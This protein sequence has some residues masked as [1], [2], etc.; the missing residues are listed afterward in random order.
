[1]KTMEF[2]VRPVAGAT[3]RGMV[4]EGVASAVINVSAGEEIS[5]N[6]RQFDVAAHV[7]S[8]NDLVM[9]LAD[10]RTVTLKGFFAEG[11]PIA[12]LFISADGYL[13]EVTLVEG[14]DGAL[15]A[16][17]GPTEM[18]GKWSP[19]EDLVF[20]DGAEV[21][22]PVAAA[23]EA[24]T[25]LAPGLLLGG[26]ALGAASGVAALAAGTALVGGL[27]GAGGGDSDAPAGGGGSGGG[28]AAGAGGDGNSGEQGGGPRQP[29]VNEKDT[30]RV[31]GDHPD[32]IRITGTAEPGAKVE[33]TVGDISVVTAPD[34]S[35]AWQVIFEGNTVPADG[36]YPAQ[37]VVTQPGGGPVIEL[38]GPPVV[39]DTTPPL[40]T[41][42]EGT[43]SAGHV[44][45]GDDHRDGVRIAGTSEPGARLE[46]TIGTV[47]HNVTVGDSGRWQ[48]DFTPSELPAGDYSRDVS[49]VARDSFN[50]NASYGDAVQVDTIPDPI[51]IHSGLVG[52]D[53]T[54]NMDEARGGYVVTGT[55]TPGNM[56]TLERFDGVTTITRTVQV[57]PNGTWRVEY[58]PGEVRQG[59]YNVTLNASTSDAAGN[60]GRA[61]ATV[62]VDTVHFV[63]I[64]PTPLG[65]NDLINRLA[66]DGGV[67]LRGTTQPGSVVEV[68]FGSI[69]REVTSVDGTWSV[70]YT[71]ADFNRLNLARNEYTDAFQVTARDAA[72]NVSTAGRTVRVDTVIDLTINDGIATDGLINA[73][74]RSAGV[75]LSGMTEPGAR[76][77]VQLAGG[78]SKPAEVEASGAWR[79]RFDAADIPTGQDTLQVS[80]TA[81]DRAGNSTS[82]NRNVL[83]DT[84]VRDFAFTSTGVAADGI[85]NGTEASATAGLVVTGTVEAGSRVFVTL[86]EGAGAVTREATVTGDTWSLRLDPSDIRAGEYASRITAVATDAAQNN[87]RIMHDMIVDTRLNRLELDRPIAGDNVVNMAESQGGLVLT[88][89]VEA[90]LANGNLSSVS[91]M[92]DGRPYQATVDAAGNWRAEVPAANIR[93]GTYTTEVIVTATDGAGNAG[94]L[95]PVSLSVDTDAPDSPFVADYTRNH[96]GISSVSI[97]TT[98]DQVSLTQVRADDTLAPINSEATVIARRGETLLDFGQTL[99]N[100]TFEATPLPD[101]SHL[102]ITA[103]DQAGNSSGTFLAFDEL[104]TSVIDLSAPLAGGMRIEAIDL[105]FAE[106]SQLTLTEA[107]ILALSPDSRSITVHGGVDDAVTLS[108]ARLVAG[109]TQTIEGRRYEIYEMG[110]ARVIVDED[111]RI[112]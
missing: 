99:G 49:V 66:A 92:F 55:S 39:I 50:N 86:G 87:A 67:T 71:A 48:V 88:G 98:A 38:A 77:M 21:T 28:G 61:N 108:G 91:V 27:A 36:S 81:T 56:L 5:L 43:V 8:G 30:I 73:A 35:G 18:W 3:R 42:T 80:A 11:E 96:S 83:L 2:V 20:V 101:G 90:A 63:T 53:G 34:G 19:H 59:E 79:V 72:G 68:R 10:G 102:V 29:T 9:T 74:E 89:R 4:E 41:F 26:G 54:V 23:N 105:S 104:S 97:N 47:T 33:V 46:V 24:V 112:L 60:I 75:W 69:L 12:R 13:S 84:E 7:R 58:L 6:L 85:I 107:Q 76:V 25:M 106:D 22:A 32:T 82:T 109:E 65:D 1:M 17:Y 62:R 111:V 93:K 110:N 16:Q 44:V 95:S 70:Q 40:V 51:V 45:N 52:G 37:V 103:T 78:T 31:G 14:A 57:Q 100:G 64:D 15:H 94:S